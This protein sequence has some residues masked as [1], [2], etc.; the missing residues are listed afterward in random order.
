MELTE[1][2]LSSKNVFDGKILHITLDEIELPD[3]S[4][5]KREVVNHPG[6][7]AVAALDENNN[8]LFVRQF[9]YPYKEVVLELPAG[10]L[11]KGSTPLEN[12]KRELIEE[13]GAEGYSY[14]SLGQLY[15]SPG[16][17]SEI[18]HLYACRIQTEGDSRPDDGEFLN[19]EKIPLD[20]AVEMVLN[21]QIPDAKSQVAI[22]KTAMLLK[23]GKI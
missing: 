14:I 5:S 4:R 23:S 20:K 10:K 16:Y 13:T 8:L 1:K 17:T 22:L 11:E 19:V 7:V 2:T 15:P 18:I 12:G 3:G 21:N 6:G 9:R